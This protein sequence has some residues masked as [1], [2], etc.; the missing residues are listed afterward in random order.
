[1]I[2]Q[3]ILGDSDGHQEVEGLDRWDMFPQPQKIMIRLVVLATVD[4]SEEGLLGRLDAPLIHRLE[5]QETIGPHGRVVNMFVSE[6]DVL[7]DGH[8]PLLALQRST[9]CDTAWRPARG[10]SGP[11]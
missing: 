8:K 1:M 2:I 4:S 11:P 9:R 5:L 7:Q 6:R 3:D 10:C